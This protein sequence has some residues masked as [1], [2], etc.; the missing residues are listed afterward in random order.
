MF[1]HLEVLQPA[2]VITST[3]AEELTKVLVAKIV[4]LK[5]SILHEVL[6]DD[7]AN[8]G[9]K[10]PLPPYRNHRRNLPEVLPAI[11]V[12]IFFPILFR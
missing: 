9:L 11:L 4:E 7:G 1:G 5:A 8:G 10:S 6:I 12:L 3:V 2:K